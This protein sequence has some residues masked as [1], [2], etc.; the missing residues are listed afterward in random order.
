MPVGLASGGV[1]WAVGFM[2]IRA[3]GGAGFFGCSAEELVVVEAGEV[4]H[5]DR[6]ENA[7][8]S[9]APTSL[10]LTLLDTCDL[11][12]A[13]ICREFSHGD[14]VTVCSCGQML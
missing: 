1:S 10:S 13:D 2:R 9:V 8:V 12:P 7:T 14:R 3:W 5:V 4:D 6:E 11:C